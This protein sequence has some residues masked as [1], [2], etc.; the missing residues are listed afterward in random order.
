MWALGL[1]SGGPSIGTRPLAG[2]A[3]RLDV[4]KLDARTA[5]LAR[6]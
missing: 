4:A 5:A 2:Q 3:G 1:F 6:A